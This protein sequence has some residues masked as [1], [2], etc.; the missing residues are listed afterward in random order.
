MMPILE[1]F[2]PPQMIAMVATMGAVLIAFTAIVGGYWTVS[3][4]RRAVLRWKRE[5]V[6]KGLSAQEIVLLTGEHV[7]E[8]AA[9]QSETMP[10]ASVVESLSDA[11]TNGIDEVV[12]VLLSMSGPSAKQLRVPSEL[13]A[14]VI[15]LAEKEYTGKNIV[16]LLT[17]MQRGVSIAAILPTPVPVPPSPASCGKPT[18]EPIA[19]TQT[20]A[21]TPDAANRP[22]PTASPEPVMTAAATQTSERSGIFD[23]LATPSSNQPDIELIMTGSEK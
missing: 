7:I 18:A 21:P 12:R 8:S 20:P 13:G 3:R 15:D 4:H 11:Q 9:P 14:M 23:D 1:R 10:V 22:A 5:L 6:E 17:T 16:E 19:V 2:S